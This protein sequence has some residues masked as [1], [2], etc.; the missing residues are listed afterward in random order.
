[1]TGFRFTFYRKESK[2][3]KGM[4][5]TESTLLQCMRANARVTTEELAAAADV[6]IRTV[7]RVVKRLKEQGVLHQ[8]ETDAGKVWVLD[9]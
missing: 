1:M 6:S 2:K 7:Q 8:L 4:T 5:Q 3:G 9:E